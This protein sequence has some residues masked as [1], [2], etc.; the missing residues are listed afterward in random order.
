[1]TCE[2]Y[3]ADFFVVSAA[4]PTRNLADAKQQRGTR[5][6]KEYRCKRRRKSLFQYLLPTSLLDNVSCRSQ[7]PR[8]DRR[9]VA[10]FAKMRCC[11]DLTGPKSRNGFGSGDITANGQ[12]V[13]GA[14]HG[15]EEMTA[16]QSDWTRVGRRIGRFLRFCSGRRRRRQSTS[17]AVQFAISA[18]KVYAATVPISCHFRRCFRRRGIA[19]TRVLD[20]F[21]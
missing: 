13:F 16:K 14:A 11:S 4:A 3:I 5:R 7:Q 18:G 10:K 20:S 6:C 17:V 19:F 21:R 15:R 9:F 2:R 12:M 1:M 8:A